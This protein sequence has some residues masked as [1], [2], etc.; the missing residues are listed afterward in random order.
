MMNTRKSHVRVDQAKIANRL[1][2]QEE[3]WQTET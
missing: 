1:L 2:P 3:L